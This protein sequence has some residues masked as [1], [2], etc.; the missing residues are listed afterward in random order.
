MSRTA[1]RFGTVAIACACVLTLLGP[2]AGQAGAADTAKPTILSVGIT[3]A[4]DSFNTTVGVLVSSYEV[5]NLQYAT[6][7]DKAADDFHTIPGL[8]ESWTASNNGR[9]YTYKL[10]PNL[11]WSDGTPLTADD[12]AYTVNR[13]R[14]EQWLNYD[15]VVTNLKAVAK[16]ATTVEITSS[17]PDPKLPTMD[18]YILPKHVYSKVS[19]DAMASYAATDGVGSG[20]FTLSSQKKNQFWN[21]KVNPNY[22]KG[23]AAIDEVDF[24]Y[25]TN[26]DAMAGALEKGEIDAAENVPASALDKLGKTP[27]VTVIQGQQG[28]FDELSIN[29]GDGQGDANPA[30]KDVKFRQA[31]AHAIDKQ[32]LITRVYGGVGAAAVGMSPSADPAWQA[33]IPADQQFGF[34]IAKANQL[35][36]AAGYPRQNG[37]GSRL[38]KDGKPI[39]LRLLLRSDSTYSSGLG[40]FIT[41]WMKELGI[42]ITTKSYSDD[43]LTPIIGKGTYDMF[44][45]G[46]TPFVDPDPQLSYF[47]CN[48]IAP[49]DDPTNYYND[50]NWC[51]SEYDKLYKE[52]NT[53][54]DKTK[55]L[56]IVHQMLTLFYNQAAYVVLDYSPDLQAYRTDRFTG[57]IRQPAKIG[58]VIFSNSSPSYFALKP[59][60]TK[61]S[62]SS[63]TALIIVIIVAAVVVLG[64]GGFVVQRRRTATE[65]D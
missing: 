26:A 2:A 62:S 30:V 64:A 54:L 8:A 38:G 27:N 53:E 42:G 49:P 43:Q 22:Y 58:P 18:V 34:D 1:R 51:S 44:I 10:R 61:K 7:T 60:S 20:P 17:V 12:V 35:L 13:A 3:Q 56:Q 47:Q 48:Q 39:T 14:D 45:W 4:V 36:D 5:W 6:L 33:D 55:R 37:T 41:G 32:T 16:D 59:I 29:A 52:Q 23:R 15:S 25:Y 57:W 9:T 63:N 65:R 31:I 28:G 50:A 40:E 11:K 24:R 19:A 46:W 21:M